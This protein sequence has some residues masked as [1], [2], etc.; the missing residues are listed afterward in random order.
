MSMFSCRYFCCTDAFF[1]EMFFSVKVTSTTAHVFFILKGKVAFAAGVW[2]IN[3][4]RDPLGW[5]QPCLVDQQGGRMTWPLL[6]RITLCALHTANWPVWMCVWGQGVGVCSDM[7]SKW[8][9]EREREGKVWKKIKRLIYKYFVILCVCVCD[10]VG[11]GL[12]TATDQSYGESYQDS[13]YIIYRDQRLEGA[14]G[15]V[16]RTVIIYIYVFSRH[17]IQ[18]DLHFYQ[19][20]ITSGPVSP[21]AA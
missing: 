16:T 9:K 15:R 8:G 18:C 14:M 11:V 20:L 10:G 21:R 5:D 6:T 1:C 4:A 3:K 19:L 12:A 17:F 13:H 2:G 7:F